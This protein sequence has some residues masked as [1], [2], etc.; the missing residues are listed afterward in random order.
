MSYEPHQMQ[1]PMDASV[2]SMRERDDDEDENEDDEDEDDDKDE[3]ED[4]DESEPESESAIEEE[5]EE[6]SALV[7]G[8][9][10]I[11]FHEYAGSGRVGIERSEIVSMLKSEVKNP[12]I[13]HDTL[14]NNIQEAIRGACLAPV[15]ALYRDGSSRDHFNAY[16]GMVREL[17]LLKVL[18][19][20]R[21]MR[22]S[23]RS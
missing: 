6:P 10:N 1:D 2:M 14:V 18:P 17:D 3:D 13:K 4:E 23:R 7:D 8:L 16:K 19:K 12:G 21:G 22:G 11:I 20:K 15:Y 9:M 5:E